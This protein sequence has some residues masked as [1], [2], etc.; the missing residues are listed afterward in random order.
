MNQEGTIRRKDVKASDI[1]TGKDNGLY[2]NDYL[3]K[4]NRIIIPDG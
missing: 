1:K 4:L 3:I 2:K